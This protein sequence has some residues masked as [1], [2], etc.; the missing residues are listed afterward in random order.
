MSVVVLAILEDEDPCVAYRK[1]MSEQRRAEVMNGPFFANV[2]IRDD[3]KVVY[4]GR[5]LSDH[6]QWD[7]R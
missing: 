3:G 2:D 4:S 5:S 6:G 1:F 7:E